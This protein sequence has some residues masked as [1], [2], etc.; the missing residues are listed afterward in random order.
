MEQNVSL[1][2]TAPYQFAVQK[3]YG[4]S[5]T[6]PLVDPRSG[7]FVGQILHDFYSNSV[8]DAFDDEHSSLS[9]TGFPILVAVQGHA[10]E[11]TVIGPGFDIGV[12]SKKISQV[13]LPD[14]SACTRSNCERN[15][16]KF[17][18]IE[19]AMK[20]GE[21]D[22]TSFVRTA[23]GGGEETVH[24]AHAPVIVKSIRAVNSSSF[25]RGVEVGDYL[26]YSLGLLETEKGLLKPFESIEDEMTRQLNWAIV[27]LAA[28]IFT[29]AVFVIYI[30]YLLTVSIT[31]PM[32]YLL[33]LIRCINW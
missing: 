21:T 7:Q 23:E 2:I 20:A 8:F 25:G 11:N 24:V 17:R 18:L 6:M 12:E 28:G 31:E 15:I 27:V 29:S 4:Q 33:D 16:E 5:S 30:S 9:E 22:L 10:E 13:V 3:L 14:D 19:K 32:L 1:H 26:I